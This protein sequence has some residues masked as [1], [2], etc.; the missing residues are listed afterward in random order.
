MLIRILPRLVGLPR[1]TRLIRPSPFIHVMFVP[2]LH[3]RC[4]D[5]E[6]NQCHHGIIPS[7]DLSGTK[8]SQVLG[9]LL[10]M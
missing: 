2:A 10:L 7:P 1:V 3:P 5:Q 8:L 6:A 9:L 4:S